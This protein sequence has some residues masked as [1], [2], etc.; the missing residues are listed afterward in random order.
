MTTPQQLSV[1]LAGASAHKS[2]SPPGRDSQGK[3]LRPLQKGHTS[4]RMQGKPEKNR[5]TVEEERDES[6]RDTITFRTPA[7]P[8]ETAED[9]C[10]PVKTKSTV[11]EQ[12]LEKVS[13]NMSIMRVADVEGLI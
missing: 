4:D 13:I 12:F 1:Q 2:P 10:R 11:I 9:L 6:L 3:G 7:C 8:T 5:A